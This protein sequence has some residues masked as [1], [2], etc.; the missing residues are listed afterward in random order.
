MLIWAGNWVCTISLLGHIIFLIFSSF[1]FLSSWGFMLNYIWHTYYS[2]CFQ[3]SS[4]SRNSLDHDG[5]RYHLKVSYFCFQ[6][7]VC[8]TLV[9]KH[10]TT[11]VQGKIKSLESQ[12]S[13]ALHFS[14]SRSTFSSESGSGPGLPSISRASGDG[15]DS[16]A[17]T[18]KL[19]EEL[20]KRDALIEVCTDLAFCLMRISR[21]LFCGW[22]LSMKGKFSYQRKRV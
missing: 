22:F 6:C 11:L 16:S 20:K 15:M 12:L 9:Y 7:L 18:K 10:S 3:L 19:E 5:L 2:P 1:L 13:D 17:V 21:P 14:E 4:N 8:I